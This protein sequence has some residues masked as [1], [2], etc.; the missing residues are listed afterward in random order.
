MGMVKYIVFCNV[1]VGG[2]SESFLPNPI[3]G[4]MTSR[5][6]RQLS[7]LALP[8]KFPSHSSLTQIPAC[9]YTSP[10]AQISTAQ[11]RTTTL[12]GVRLPFPLSRSRKRVK[13]VL[14]LVLSVAPRRSVSPEQL[15]SSLASLPPQSMTL[16][17]NPALVR[18]RT[19]TA[20]M[21]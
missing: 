9:F 13:T 20:R 16:H 4:S 17:T 19:I 2:A 5:P 7:F 1:V 6:Q 11:R 18:L 3:L 12:V 21:N 15:R 8:G 10:K 14:L